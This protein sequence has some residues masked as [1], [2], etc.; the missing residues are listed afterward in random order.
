MKDTPQELICPL[1]QSVSVRGAALGVPM[2]HEGRNHFRYVGSVMFF[3]LLAWQP[4]RGFVAVPASS[5]MRRYAAN[6][7]E[8]ER[9]TLGCSRLQH[10]VGIP[11]AASLYP[12]VHMLLSARAQGS[13]CLIATVCFATPG[14]ALVRWG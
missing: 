2:A 3:S 4:A 9:P 1:P 14:L 11:F 10:E 6:G 7:L 5:V 12:D 8:R 13:R